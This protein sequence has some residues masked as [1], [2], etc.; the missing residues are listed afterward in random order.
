MDLLVTTDWLAAHLHD[1]DL[2]V[3]DCSVRLVPDPAVQY[4]VEDCRVEYRA[5]H[6]PGAGYIDLHNE[7][8]DKGTQLR[9]MAPTPEAFARAMSAYG[10]GDGTRVVLYAKS[11]WYWAMRV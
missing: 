9:F 1:P 10:V 4:R 3:F 8:S 6:V 5:S 2:R 11:T 7:L